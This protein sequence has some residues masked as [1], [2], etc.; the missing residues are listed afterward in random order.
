VSDD[1]KAGDAPDRDELEDLEVAD[2]QAEEIR[3]GLGRLGD[4]D[5]GS[6]NG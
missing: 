4:P 6:A 3:G 5:M 2:Q 1:Q